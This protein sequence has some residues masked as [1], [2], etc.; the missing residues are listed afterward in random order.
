[1]SVEMSAV[2]IRVKEN[3]KIFINVVGMR[4]ECLLFYIHIVKTS[5]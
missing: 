1:M 5:I 3:P 2:G 4:N